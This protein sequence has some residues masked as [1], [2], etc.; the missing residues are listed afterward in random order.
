MN[1]SLNMSKVAKPNLDK[2]LFWDWKYE[3]I[4]WQATYLSVIA[5]VIERGTDEEI[6]ELIRF[7]GKPRIVHALLCEI[8]YLPDYAIDKVVLYFDIEQGDMLCFKRKKL[9]KGYWI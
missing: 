7:Y 8:V 9:R 6:E 2:R 1:E 3:D 4:D 5:R